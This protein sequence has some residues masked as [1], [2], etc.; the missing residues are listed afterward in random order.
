MTEIDRA[1]RL[2]GGPDQQRQ[3]QVQPGDV[4]TLVHQLDGVTPVA[5]ADVEDLRAG[6]ASS[7]A[8][9]NSTSRRV[10]SGVMNGSVRR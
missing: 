6:D 7:E 2:V 1:L 5:A 9:M 10:C 8:S 4:E 3:R